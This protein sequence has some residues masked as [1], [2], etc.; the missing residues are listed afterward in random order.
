MKKASFLIL[1]LS[2]AFSS[3]AFA[4]EP[5]APAPASP[6]AVATKEEVVKVEAAVGHRPWGSGMAEKFGRGVSNIAFS[7]LEV[8]YRIGKEME[9]VDPIAGFASGALK[10]T[11]WFAARLIAGAFDVATFIIPTKP[12]IREFDAGWWA[13]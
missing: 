8:P 12:I 2:I 11:V 10:G 7:P 1:I 5:Q 13:A 3:F 4:E 9:Y 6:V